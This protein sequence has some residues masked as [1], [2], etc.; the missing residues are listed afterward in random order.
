MRFEI[1]AIITTKD[2]IFWDVMPCRLA[3]MHRHLFQ[4]ALMPLSPEHMNKKWRKKQKREDM[5]LSLIK[6]KTR[7]TTVKLKN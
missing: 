4:C 2:A 5:E 6:N 7:S 3:D 1:S